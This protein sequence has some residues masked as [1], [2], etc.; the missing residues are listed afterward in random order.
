MRLL[1]VVYGSLTHLIFF[2][3]DIQLDGGVVLT[4][5]GAFLLLLLV[6]GNHILPAAL[7]GLNLAA[8]Q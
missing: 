1:R 7:A 5:V 4:S 8:A 3:A 6:A 2:R